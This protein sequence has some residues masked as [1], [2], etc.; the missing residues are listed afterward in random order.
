MRYETL[1]YINPVQ[2]LTSG[3]EKTQ[4]GNNFQKIELQ[5]SVCCLK[6]CVSFMRQCRCPF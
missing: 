2:L 4:G 1:M 6:E 3:G 5:L